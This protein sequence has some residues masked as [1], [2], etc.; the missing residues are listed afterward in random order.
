MYAVEDF[1]KAVPAVSLGEQESAM[2]SLVAKAGAIAVASDPATVSAARATCAMASG[3][4]GTRRPL[5]VLRF[6][7]DNLNQ[8]PPELKTRL[9]SGRYRQA[10]VGAC[11]SMERS[12][13]TSYNFAVLLYP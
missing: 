9:A 8:L 2:A 5:F 3:F 4:A 13:F 6:T 12:A 10:A 11:A 7:S 1:V